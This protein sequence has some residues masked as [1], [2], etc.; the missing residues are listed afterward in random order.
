MYYYL[1]E[2]RKRL[3]SDK[4]NYLMNKHN[5][6]TNESNEETINQTTS[7][8]SMLIDVLTSNAIHHRLQYFLLSHSRLLTPTCYA[9][10][11]AMIGSQSV[12]LAKSSS[13]LIKESIEKNSQFNDPMTYVFITGLFVT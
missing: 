13:L 1:N 2:Y 11:S 6:I 9:L 12:V 8:G 4:L 5:A 3:G 7:S 10:V